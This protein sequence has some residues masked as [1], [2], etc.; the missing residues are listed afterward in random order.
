MKLLN[1]KVIWLMVAL[2][3]IAVVTNAQRRKK[4]KANKETKEWRYEI[5]GVRTGT[6]GTCLVKVWSYSKKP[7][8]AAEQAKKNAV[9]GIVFKGYAGKNRGCR[10]QKALVRDVNA[11][12]NNKAFFD[13]FFADGGKF[14]KFVTLST[15]GAVGAKDI[16]KISRKQYKVG[17]VVSVR[18]DDLRKY[19]EA[20]GI[21]K[22]LSSGF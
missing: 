1:G 12:E 16:M 10:P 4:K 9:H 8:V 21:I 11:E 20:E 19:L 7:Q 18:K 6:E 2:M 14:M 22:G 5:E 15:D 17:V 3:S 13:K